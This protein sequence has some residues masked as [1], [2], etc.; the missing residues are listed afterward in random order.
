ML[1]TRS[2][3]RPRQH[4]APTRLLLLCAS[5]LLTVQG[6]ANAK[7]YVRWVDENGQ[8]HIGH[9]VPP[10]YKDQAVE[11]LNDQ[12][13]VTDKMP[14]APTPEELKQIQ[15]EA[16]RQATREALAQRQAQYRDNLLKSYATIADL[17]AF[18]KSRM[19]SLYFRQSIND[20]KV[21]QLR[22]T[23]GQLM[24]EAKEFNFPYAPDSVLPAIPDD[25]L[26]Q[27]QAASQAMRERQEDAETLRRKLL[28][29]ESKFESDLDIFRKHAPAEALAQGAA[30]A[31]GGR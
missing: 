3:H 20:H 28:E 9:S 25:L 29:Q 11:T 6:I 24:T 30:E 17:E 21:S 5:V 15:L 31:A 8:I 12:G 26:L 18:H 14:R 19:D 7:E 22:N 23:L 4:P 27:L 13:V 16:E 10:Q 2:H 1:L